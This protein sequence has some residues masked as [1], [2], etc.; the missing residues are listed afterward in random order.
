MSSLVTFSTDRI[1]RLARSIESIMAGGN[2]ADV[3]GPDL[4][5]LAARIPSEQQVTPGA[6]VRLSLLNDTLRVAE[7]ALKADGRISSAE[8]RYFGPL[9][10]EAQKYLGRFRHVYRDVDAADQLGVQHFL[11]QHAA[12][13]QQFGGRCKSTA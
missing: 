10:G 1:E 3:I 2:S 9:V 12:D 13:G 8:I 4:T 6:V 5:S 7:R 11:E